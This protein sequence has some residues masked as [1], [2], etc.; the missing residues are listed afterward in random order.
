MNRTQEL[1]KKDFWWPNMDERVAT[2]HIINMMS[3]IVRCAYA[4]WLLTG[5]LPDS[6][7]HCQFRVN[8]GK[9][10]AWPTHL[11]QTKTGHTVIH[12]IIDQLTKLTHIVPTTENAT[13]LD[14]AEMFINI[15]VKHHGL[16]R[17]IISYQTE[18]QNLLVNS[19]KPSVS[20]LTSK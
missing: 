14:V 12:V 5:S 20:R 2:Y 8:L 10:L 4:I 16:P 9:I 17:T 13:A 15:V 6:Y 1:L 7:S 3:I 18:M 19:G 11:P